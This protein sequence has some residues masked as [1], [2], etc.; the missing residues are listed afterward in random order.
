VH[1]GALE[2]EGLKE[3]SIYRIADSAKEYLILGGENFM[4][5]RLAF[6]NKEWEIYTDFDQIVTGKKVWDASE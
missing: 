4:L 2:R 5:P 3:T 6:A 1:L